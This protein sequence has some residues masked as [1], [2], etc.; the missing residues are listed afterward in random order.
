M[1]RGQNGLLDD[2]TDADDIL[3]PLDGPANKKRRLQ[4]RKE[5]C[6]IYMIN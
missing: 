1:N 2:A 5:G 4:S 3:L 6:S